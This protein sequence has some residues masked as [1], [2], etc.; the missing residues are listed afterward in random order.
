MAKRRYADR[1][2]ITRTITATSFDM[3]FFNRETH[4]IQ[5]AHFMLAG[6]L[7][8][9]KM[10]SSAPDGCVGLEVTNVQCTETLYVCDI[11]DFIKVAKPVVD[12]ER[13]NKL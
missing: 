3:S 11:E 4:E 10:L 2:K 8:E 5:T 6:K 7:T 12:N 9:K 1:G 13:G